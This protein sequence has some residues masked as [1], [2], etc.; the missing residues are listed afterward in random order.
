MIMDS[1]ENRDVL[2]ALT[3]RR[4]D[5]FDDADVTESND[6]ILVR[7]VVFSRD[8]SDTSFDDANLMRD[9]TDGTSTGR[10]SNTA[11]LV[12]LNSVVNIIICCKQLSSAAS[13]LYAGTSSLSLSSSVG[14]VTCFMLGLRLTHGAR[15]K[16]DSVLLCMG[17]FV[18]S[19]SGI[20]FSTL[21]GSAFC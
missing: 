16:G 10:S 9:V 17:G 2:C 6:V 3:G 19:L 18:W 4:S 8:V 21:S 12:E 14:D 20:M 1:A 7:P 15:L 11:S 5:P 13:K